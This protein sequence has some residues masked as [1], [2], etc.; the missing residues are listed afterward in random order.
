MVEKTEEQQANVFRV[1]I[2]SV[3]ECG[4]DA[5]RFSDESG[6]LCAKH[7]DMLNFLTWALQNVKIK[8]ENETKSGL[9]IPS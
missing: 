6:N 4:R 2:C 3:P 1:P 8:S 5:I 7:W 9:I